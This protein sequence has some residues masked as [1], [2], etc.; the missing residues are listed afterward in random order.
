[1]EK[2]DARFAALESS[3]EFMK[4]VTSKQGSHIAEIKKSVDGMK[5]IKEMLAKWMKKQGITPDEEE[6]SGKKGNEEETGSR[7]SDDEEETP[8]SWTKKVE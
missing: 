1:M 5:G 2:I 8:R 4:K 6:P 7:G 3:V